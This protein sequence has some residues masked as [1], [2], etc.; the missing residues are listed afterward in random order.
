M[1]CG[2]VRFAQVGVWECVVGDERV[3][4]GAVVVCQ[5]AEWGGAVVALVVPVGGRTVTGA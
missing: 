4:L 5:E 1:L 2:G 3:A